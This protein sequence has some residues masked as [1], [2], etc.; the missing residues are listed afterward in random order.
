MQKI[1]E[2]WTRGEGKSGDWIEMRNTK[3]YKEIQRGEGGIWRLDWDEKYKA[4]SVLPN[5]H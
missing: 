3:K 1:K 4:G 2:N 5:C